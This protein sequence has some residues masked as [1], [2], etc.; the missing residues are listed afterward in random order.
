M[1]MEEYCRAC[2]RQCSEVD[3]RQIAAEVRDSAYHIIDAKGATNFAVGLALVKITTSIIRDEDS[4]LTVSTLI[5]G[6]CGISGVCLSLPTILNSGGV[7]RVI[8]PS[9]TEAEQA[10][11]TSSAEAIRE[12]QDQV[13]LP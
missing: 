6:Q 5:S 3:R 1:N 10:A 7:D 11:L 12:I 13:G 8:C 4:V 2:H 9:L